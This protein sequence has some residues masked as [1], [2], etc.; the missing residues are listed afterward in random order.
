MYA[1]AHMPAAAA[2][3]CEHSRTGKKHRARARCA[4]AA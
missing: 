1:H 4:Q 3:S 2:T